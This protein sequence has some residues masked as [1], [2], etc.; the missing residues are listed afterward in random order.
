MSSKN[1]SGPLLEARYRRW[2]RAYPADHRRRY[3]E[4]MIGVLLAGA[5][6]GRRHPRVRETA[7]LVRG[8][9]VVRARYA[10]T[11]YRQGDWQEA[12]ALFALFAPLMLLLGVIRYTL[13][14]AVMTVRIIES[15]AT[16]GYQPNWFVTF[17]TLPIWLTSGAVVVLALLGLRRAAAI[18]A[19]LVPVSVLGTALLVS[20][21]LGTSGV[22]SSAYPVMLLLGLLCGSALLLVPEGARPAG[23]LAGGRSGIAVA[24]ACTVVLGVLS[25]PAV[26]STIGVGG[27]A[28]TAVL[29]AIP[30]M[31][32]LLLART[33]PGRR[34]SIL[35]LTPFAP[36]AMLLFEDLLQEAGAGP[37]VRQI[38][39]PVLYFGVVPLM[40]LAMVLAA[41]R[42]MRGSGPA[43]G[44][45]PASAEVGPGRA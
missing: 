17:H 20:T 23:A 44:A 36:I 35:L 22:P 4:E 39:A 25:A 32:V 45:D 14:T 11:P 34:A 9:L 6:P 2:L 38:P 18:C 26:M 12:L 13:N 29:F 19:L 37:I 28:N 10:L 1:A 42:L 40:V 24:V 31:P 7:D 3:A 33:R 5:E 43:A 16:A 8:G 15:A 27:T 41:P 30:A 21:Q